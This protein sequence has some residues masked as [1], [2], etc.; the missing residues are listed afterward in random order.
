MTVLR[1][2]LGATPVSITITDAAVTVS[3]REDF[4]VA[5]DRGG[6]LYSVFDAGVTFRRGLNGRVLE[7]RR[8]DGVRQRRWAR[9]DECGVLV[10]RAAQV[11]AE[12]LG[13][14]EAFGSS[15]VRPPGLEDALGRAAR[16][17][18]RAAA[19]DAGR[20]RQIYSP[21]GILPP[22]QYLALVLQATEGCSFRSCTF[23]EFYRQ[24]YRVRTAADF[25]AHVAAVRDYLGDSIRLRG[26][27]VFLGSANALAVG[28]GALE[29]IFDVLTRQ[30][31][32]RPV[33]AFLDGF[34]GAMKSAGEYAALGRRG[35]RR[36]Y[37]GLESGHDPL[38]AFVQKPSTSGQAVET[39]RAIKAGG[40]RVG[41][42]V[43]IG[44]GG[45]RY[46]GAHVADTAAAVNAMG[47][48]A[49][50]LL[51]FSDL[52]ESA[53]SPYPRFARD[54]SIRSLTADERRLQ[55][56]A[57]ETRLKFRGP[58]PRMATYDIREFVY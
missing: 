37:V 8:E 14:M 25:A 55:R 46:M 6:R 22:D 40:V 27:S 2:S 52:V 10:D 12:L 19:A 16:F 31:P 56:R 30:V 42:I 11:A 36:V 29:A 47:L 3:R 54:A 41:V 33:H 39:V 23:C 7:K 50:D 24:P 17:D 21:I 45:D 20:F 1:G 43:L 13:A 44:L 58:S 34:A 5:W 38:L 48:D 51:Y 35:L 49:G 26:R 15:G 4:V 18:A 32:G 9:P 28:T 57:I 53:D